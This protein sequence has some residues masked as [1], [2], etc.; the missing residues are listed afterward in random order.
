MNN[1]FELS[2]KDNSGDLLRELERVSNAALEAVGL[3]AEAHAKEAAPVGT[4]RSTGVLNYHGGTLRKSITHK[5]VGGEVYIGTN[6]SVTYK[7]RRIHYP[8]Y[9][10]YGTGI[11]A[12]GGKGR[13]SPWVWRDKN[14]KYHF[15][16]GMKPTHFL[17]NSISNPKHIQE[18]K[19]IIKAVMQGDL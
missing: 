13:Q 19:T 17:K 1:N 18:Y 5:V 4:T 9:V 3:A 12:D 7:G 8:I 6:A 16:R 2:F 14:G 11:Y 10:E 15:T